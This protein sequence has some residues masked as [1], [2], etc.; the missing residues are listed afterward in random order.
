MLPGDSC[1]TN[2]L[3]DGAGGGRTATSFL[4][5]P[6]EDLTLWG[7][8]EFWGTKHNLERHSQAL[9]LHTAGD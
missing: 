7:T 5:I 6:T 3:K 9:A 8:N 4:S 1:R 2:K